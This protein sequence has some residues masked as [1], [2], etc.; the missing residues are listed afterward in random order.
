MVSAPCV[1]G[2]NVLGGRTCSENGV[3]CD[4]LFVLLERGGVVGTYAGVAERI[5]VQDG[6]KVFLLQCVHAAA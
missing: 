3:F 6:G 5:V 1:L 2:D 4:V